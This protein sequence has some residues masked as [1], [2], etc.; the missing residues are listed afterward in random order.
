VDFSLDESTEQ[1]RAQARRFFDEEFP[2]DLQLRRFEWPFDWDWNQRLASW[3]DKHVSDQTAMDQLVFAE[4]ADRAGADL[5]ILNP[6]ITVLKTLLVIGNEYQRTELVPLLRQ[7]RALMSLGYTEPDGGSDLA[8]AKTRAVRDGDEWIIN[9]NKIFTS[10]ANI[11]THIWLLARTDP[12]VPK[13]AGLTVFILPT[14]T[15]G[16]EVQTL[17]TLAHHPTCVTYY[18]DVRVP[19]AARVGDVNDGW[20]VVKL[21]LSFERSGSHSFLSTLL[22]QVV[23]WA[24]ETTLPDGSKPIDHWTVRERLA[25][26]ALDDELS[27]LLL[28]RVSWSVAC[29]GTPGP[30]ANQ[31]KLF[32]SEAYLRHANALLDMIELGGLLPWTESQAPVNGWVDYAIRDAPVRTLGGGSS[33]VQRDIIAQRCLGLPRNRPKASSEAAKRAGPS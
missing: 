6:T 15:S 32:G 22:P 5:T 16:V 8:A 27:N 2:R 19:D 13:Q 25:R 4:E 18:S 21:A 20:S 30:E 3:R 7:G 11:A 17:R 29:N 1:F 12:D 24:Q 28:Q 31:A 10:H 23:A 14:S 26:M 33:E 9:G